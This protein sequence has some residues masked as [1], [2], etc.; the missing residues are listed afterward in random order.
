LLGHGQYIREIDVRGDV[1]CV[2]ATHYEGPDLAAWTRDLGPRVAAT[3]YATVGLAGRCATGVE[4]GQEHDWF[5]QLR[6]EYNR[7]PKHNAAHDVTLVVDGIR[8]T[9]GKHASPWQFIG[10]RAR[11]IAE[12]LGEPR[13]WRA[14]NALAD[15][16]SREQ[17]LSGRDACEVIVGAWGQP[18]GWPILQLG[19]KWGERFAPKGR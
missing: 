12:L 14:V 5:Q 2:G 3:W 18:D 6:D 13:V 8:K 9:L 4:Q 1:N 7:S 19:L 17:R 11:W 16:L 10:V 15:R